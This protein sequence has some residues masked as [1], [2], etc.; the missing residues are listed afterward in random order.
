MPFVA[1]IIAA[2]TAPIIK[3]IFATISILTTHMSISVRTFTAYDHRLARVI[4]IMLD[5]YVS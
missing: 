4:H 2:A 1:K 3:M 5:K